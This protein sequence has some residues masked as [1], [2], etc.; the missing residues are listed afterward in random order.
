M[1]QLLGRAGWGRDPLWGAVY[2]RLVED[3]RVGAIAWRAGLGADLRR[4]HAA[5]GELGDLPAGSRVLDLPCGGGVA[6]R[7]VRAGQGLDLVAADLDPVMLE[8]TRVR[9]ERRGVLDQVTLVEADVGALP[10][11]DASFDCV[12]S[13][14]GLHCFPDPAGAVRELVRVLRPGGR[15]IGST[16][17]EDPLRTLPMRVAGRAA[18]LLGP[19]VFAD[20]LLGLLRGAGIRDAALERDG[21]VAYF[22]GTRSR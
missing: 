14:T 2:H 21:A 1:R 19:V 22:R 3:E 7:G 10:F 8:R 9:A 11:E 12:A 4:L 20:E 18:G 15:L 13:F 5:V 17:V 6:L 16:L